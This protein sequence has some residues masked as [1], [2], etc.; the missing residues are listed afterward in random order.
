MSAAED[1]RLSYRFKAVLLS[2]LVMPGVGQAICGRVLR[3]MA[4]MGLTTLVFLGLLVKVTVMFTTAVKAF[5]ASGAKGDWLPHVAAYMRHQ[6]DFLFL[7]LLG[8]LAGL[9]IYGVLDA[10]REGSRID[11]GLAAGAAG[12]G[13]AAA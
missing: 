10:W 6:A 9:W 7:V 12:N 8:A 5:K 1:E 3:G 11:A 13:G 4:L 2:G